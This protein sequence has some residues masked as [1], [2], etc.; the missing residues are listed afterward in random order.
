MGSV[1]PR[2]AGLALAITLAIQAFVSM[3]AV[4]V[5]V[6][7]PAIAADMG[8]A[9]AHLGMFVGLVFLTAMASSASSGDVILRFGALR[10]SQAC[11]ALS[12]AGLAAAATGH[13]PLFALG[14]V[15]IGL[16]YGPLNPASSQILVRTTPRHLMSLTFS[17]KQTGVPVGAA[18]A[19]AVVPQLER[20][21]G[22]ES[23]LLAVAVACA[24]VALASQSV[25]EGFDD[26]RQP[27]RRI[28]YRSV[29]EPLALLMRSR[30]LVQLAVASCVFMGVQ[31]CLV[32]YLV[33]YLTDEL[34]M[35]LI[36]AGLA[37]SVAQVAGIVGRIA[38]GAIADRFMR[39]R[40]L[41]ALLGAGMAIASVATSFLDPGWPY[42]V[43][44]V[45]IALFGATA[46][47][48]NGV[49]LAEV[50]R[51]APAGKVGTITGASMSI[52]YLGVVVAPPAFG[53]LVTWLGAFSGGFRAAAVAALAMSAALILSFRTRPRGELQGGN[54]P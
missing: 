31:L 11:L 22:W 20:W 48:W 12:A 27:G 38:W 25:R 43:A 50:A 39:P 10:T 4:T 54:A 24:F 35:S 29:I 21:G 15:L 2:A 37:L 33:I 5:P 52:T 18:L 49:Y 8:I 51:L 53:A 26:D 42:A 16:A 9:S 19:G 30:P 41:L 40:L 23:G 46:I 14:A 28:S 1:A 34:G 7:A 44:M 13:L 32:T 3:A 45:P 6:L 47:G 17:L 36:S